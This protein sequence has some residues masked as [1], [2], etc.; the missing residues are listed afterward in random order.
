MDTI[1]SDEG[2]DILSKA[3]RVVIKLGSALVVDEEG[4]ADAARVQAISRDVINLLDEGKEVAIVCSG[5]VVLGRDALGLGSK[6]LKLEEKQASA[7]AGQLRLMRT[8][9]DAFLVHNIPVAQAL[10]TIHDTEVRRRWL[11]ARATLNTLL[12][13]GAVP[14]INENDTVATDGIR[15]GDNDRLAARVAQMISADVLILLSDIDGLYTADPRSNPDAKHIPVVS[16]LTD[17]IMAMGGDANAE[18]GVGSGGMAT[19]LIAA[20]I[21]MTAGC[22][23]VIT[24]GDPTVDTHDLPISALKDGALATWFIPNVSP[25]T[26]RKQW[27]MG[28]LKPSGKINID[29]GAAKAVLDGKNLLPVGIVSIEG[30]FDRGDCVEVVDPENIIIA[31]GLSA[32]SS[33]DAIKLIGCTTDQIEDIVGYKGRPALIHTEDMVKL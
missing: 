28:A 27:L 14:I 4:K 8:W 18:A 30:Y 16:D 6:T 3:K 5:A 15:Y 2:L 24:Q 29:K 1:A 11:N 10:L 26:A 31:R 17:E 32:Y 21:A 9:E 23:T 19:K 13:S 22:S 12:A 7:A 33:E 25:D 20:Q